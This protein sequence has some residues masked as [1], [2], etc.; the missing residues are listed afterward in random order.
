MN[1]EKKK[2]SE[3]LGQAQLGIIPPGWLE[4]QERL[5]KKGTFLK[6]GEVPKASKQF[7]PGCC[8]FCGWNPAD[9]LHPPNFC[10]ECG[11]P[12]PDISKTVRVGIQ[13]PQS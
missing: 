13:V 2:Q 4:E 9:P 5:A 1:E 8:F 3:I 12:F 10:P 7:L 11:N 6:E